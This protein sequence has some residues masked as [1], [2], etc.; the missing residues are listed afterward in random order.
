MAGG[1]ERQMTER[2]IR[3]DRSRFE[4][5]VLCLY[6]ERLQRSLHFLEPLQAAGIRVEVLNL[7]QNIV[8]K[9]RGVSGITRMVWRIKAHI[10]HSVNYHS[11]LLARLAR[12]LLPPKMSL[13]SS[14]SSPRNMRYERLS[15][16]L[17][18]VIVCNSPHI[19]QQLIDQYAQP[20]R[21]IVT[22]Y[23]G[24]DLERFGHLP[25]TDMQLPLTNVASRVLL[26][27]GRLTQAKGAHFLVEA[28]GILNRRGDIPPDVQIIMVG[29][30]DDR[31]RTALNALIWHCEL[32]EI[33]QIHSP[34]PHPERYYQIAS[35]SVLASLWEGLP[36]VMLESLA[37]GRP[38]IISEAANQAGVI[39]HGV[40]GWVVRTNDVE[41][42]ANT[43]REVL[44]LPDEALL[45]MRASCQES[46]KPF[47]MQNMVEQ[48]QML[49]ERVAGVRK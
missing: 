18:N 37:A 24:I 46:A 39:Q 34:T 14:I 4:P 10:L 45:A 32:N 12:P 16:W 15:G 21:R 41:H 7:G 33:V 28:A 29:E 25:E 6:G 20:P 13:I 42:L 38:V 2:I 22:M 49:Y 35:V 40:N 3:L 36:N 17:S 1:V 30:S 43:L 26:M 47:A 44:L 11:N 8:D 19:R 5:Y 31:E 9:V 27:V 48:Y 23:N